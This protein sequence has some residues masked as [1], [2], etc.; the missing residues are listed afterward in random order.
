MKWLIVFAC[1]IGYTAVAAQTGYR[2]KVYAFVQKQVNGGNKH[3]IYIEM[4]GDSIPIWDSAIIERKKFVVHFS[5][6]EAVPVKIG[7]RKSDKKMVVI[8]TS[9]DCKMWMVEFDAT[10]EI[11]ASAD[12]S[13]DNAAVTFRGKFKGRKVNYKILSEVELEGED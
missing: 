8:K 5:P 13:T 9:P 1:V 10:N 4:S 3:F 2:Q 7:H 12:L 6:V 11:I